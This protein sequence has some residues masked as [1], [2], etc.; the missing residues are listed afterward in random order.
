[1]ITR[2]DRVASEG[3]WV[4]PKL[5]PSSVTALASG[6]MPATEKPAAVVSEPMIETT[7]G[8]SNARLSRSPASI[9]RRAA[10]SGVIARSIDPGVGRSL[11]VGRFGLAVTATALSCVEF[12]VSVA[13]AVRRS[14]SAS[15]I[16]WICWGASPMA[17]M[18]TTYSPP[19][20]GKRIV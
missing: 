12:N 5:R 7:E 4:E 11:P 18:T 15:R 14:S 3:S 6:R 13:S 17:L 9:G 2:V 10:C 8:D 16:R 20:S 1:M 19:P